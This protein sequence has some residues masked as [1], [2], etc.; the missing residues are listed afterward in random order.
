MKT[1][2]LVMSLILLISCNKKKERQAKCEKWKNGKI[3]HLYYKIE[4]GTSSCVTQ[5]CIDAYYIQVEEEY[6][7]CLKKK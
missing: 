6:Q 7:E 1:V 5:E 4:Q 2:L 3:A